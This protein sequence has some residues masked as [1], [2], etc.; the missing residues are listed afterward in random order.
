[1]AISIKTI[2]RKLNV[3]P[4]TVSRALAGMPGVSE[5]TRR[6]VRSVA[7]E[8]GYVPDTHA[9]DLRTQRRT[10]VGIICRAEPTAVTSARNYALLEHGRTSVGRANLIVKNPS[11]PLDA[12]VRRALSEKY[13]A[14]ILNRPG[15]SLSEGL[16]RRAVAEGVAMVSIDQAVECVDAIEIDR[17]IGTRQA[18]RLLLGAGR[19]SIAILAAADLSDPDPRLLGFMDGYAERGLSLSPAALVPLVSPD[20]GA[21]YDIGVRLFASSRRRRGAAP[22]A[23]FCY[24]DQVAIGVLRAAVE[25]GVEVGSEVYLV[26][27]DDLEPAQYLPVSLTTVSQPI[28]E[29]AQAAIALA[30][31]RIAEPRRPRAVR[32]FPTRLVIRE[33]APRPAGLSPADIYRD[34]GDSGV[35]A[36]RTKR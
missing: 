6:R 19:R 34:D 13:A 8:L 3:N 25:G 15:G 22:D 14:L 9:R 11:E 2:A 30:T 20:I 4:S 21:G 31:G 33:S 10:S 18:A 7:E 17:R 1:M 23:V 28:V 27:F 32:R 35:A 29:C 5:E 24:S 26:G 36:G 12:V 16:V